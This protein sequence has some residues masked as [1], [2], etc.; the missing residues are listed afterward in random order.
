MRRVIAYPM[1]W[2]HEWTFVEIKRQYRTPFQRML[3]HDTVVLFVRIRYN[4]ELESTPF[5]LAILL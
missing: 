5:R 4:Q 3:Q 2:L 1:R